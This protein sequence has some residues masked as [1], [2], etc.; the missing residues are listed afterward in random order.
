[1]SSIILN[2]SQLPTLTAN[3]KVLSINMKK[4]KFNAS[5]IVHM[6]PDSEI[7]TLRKEY[8]ELKR[9]HHKDY[10]SRLQAGSDYATYHVSAG[11]VLEVYDWWYEAHKDRYVEVPIHIDSYSLHNDTKQPIPFDLSDAVRHGHIKTNDTLQ[12]VKLFDL[13]TVDISTDDYTVKNEKQLLTNARASEIEIEEL[14]RQI[15]ELRAA[16]QVDTTA[17]EAKTTTTKKK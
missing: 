10:Q 15:A 1:M 14:K 16:A 17:T 12:R 9:Y 11:D 2:N 3:R 5:T 4:V 7:E 8:N 13:V 6:L